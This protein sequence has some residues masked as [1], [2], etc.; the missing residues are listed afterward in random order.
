MRR[1]SDSGACVVGAGRPELNSPALDPEAWLEE[2][3]GAG[4]TWLSGMLGGDEMLGALMC[5]ALT[6]GA[7][8]GAGGAGAGG[9]GGGGGGAGGGLGAA[10]GGGLGGGALGALLGCCARTM[11]GISRTAAR[12]RTESR[13]KH[14]RP[15]RTNRRA[16]RPVSSDVGVT[17]NVLRRCVKVRRI[18]PCKM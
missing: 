10:L 5:E 2:E 13:I 18:A 17:M 16:G 9:G 7:A 4:V 3:I 14:L 15:N 11:V 12:A 1:A 6:L 8:L